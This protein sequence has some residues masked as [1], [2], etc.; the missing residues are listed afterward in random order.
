[1]RADSLV[2]PLAAAASV[3]GAA[4]PIR[5]GRYMFMADGT[6]GGST[7]SLQIQ[8]PDGTWSTVGALGGN[9]VV[10]TTTL[11][12]SVT[13]IDLPAGNVRAAITGGAGVSLTATLAGIG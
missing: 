7:V 1:M 10:Q 5:G 6:A 9:A 2:Y 8:C 3:T 11:P 13:P 12:Y 4:V